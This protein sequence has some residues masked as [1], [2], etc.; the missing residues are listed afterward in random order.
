MSNVTNIKQAADKRD[1]LQAVHYGHL[2]L[3]V[4]ENVFKGDFRPR[5][6]LTV[7]HDYTKGTVGI[8]ALNNARKWVQAAIDDAAHCAVKADYN[9]AWKMHPAIMALYAIYFTLEP[10]IDIKAVSEKAEEAFKYEDTERVR[11]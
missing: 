9:G 1:R 2:V 5:F 7:A 6:A 3:D 10:E 4:Y 8:A 11:G